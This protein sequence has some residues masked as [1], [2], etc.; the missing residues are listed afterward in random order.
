LGD[1]LKASSPKGEKTCPEPICTI[2]QHFTPI[3]VIGAEISVS[4]QTV[5]SR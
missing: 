2:V 5:Y 1:L 3:G 4:G